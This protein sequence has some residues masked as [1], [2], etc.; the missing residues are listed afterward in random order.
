MEEF[1]ILTFKSTHESI[2]FE[3]I[4]MNLINVRLVPIPTEITAGCGMC[5]K[6]DIDKLDFV[7]SK[8]KEQSMEF[9]KIYKV[10]KHGFNKQIEQIIL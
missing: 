9:D 5:L 2:H 10:T 3:Q 6:F 4:F 1:L 7:L 8:A